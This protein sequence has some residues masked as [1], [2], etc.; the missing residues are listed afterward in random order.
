MLD[1]RHSC[2]SS[3][4]LTFLFR[5]AMKLA[6]VLIVLLTTV[7]NAA[8]ARPFTDL[9]ALSQ[10]KLLPPRRM[11]R[12]LFGS[13]QMKISFPAKHTTFGASI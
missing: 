7:A 13:R 4:K 9:V 8:L 2:M 12:G 3:L 5:M 10:I 6:Y 11:E 1:M